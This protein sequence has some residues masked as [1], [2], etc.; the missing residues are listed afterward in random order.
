VEHYWQG[1]L[2]LG[3]YFGHELYCFSLV[4][5]LFTLCRLFLQLHLRRIVLNY[6]RNM[7]FNIIIILCILIQLTARYKYHILPINNVLLAFAIFPPIHHRLIPLISHQLL[8]YLINCVTI[9]Q[10]HKVQLLHNLCNR[11]LCRL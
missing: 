6:K 11:F 2:I 4:F 5:V 3:D 9:G 7:L 8:N 10:W 1:W